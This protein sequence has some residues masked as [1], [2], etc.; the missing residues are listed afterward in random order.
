M[1]RPVAMIVA[2]H[3]AELCLSK[4]AGGL[5]RYRIG[6]RNVFAPFLG[7]PVAHGP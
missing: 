4:G 6:L 7:G 1:G 3:S 2:G 5:G